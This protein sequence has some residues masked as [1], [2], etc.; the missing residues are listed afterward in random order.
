VSAAE[1]LEAADGAGLAAAVPAAFGPNLA[2]QM[3][4]A[5]ALCSA[6][7]KEQEPGLPVR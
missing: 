7:L 1:V 5:H 2:R 3:T 6:R 4:T